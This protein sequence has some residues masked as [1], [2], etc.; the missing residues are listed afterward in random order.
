MS[1][2]IKIYG[3]GKTVAKVLD[4]LRKEFKPNIKIR[5]GTTRGKTFSVVDVR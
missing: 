3:N 5:V 4:C 2:T 1:A